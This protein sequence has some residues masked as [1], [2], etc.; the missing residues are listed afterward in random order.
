MLHSQF[1][2][3]IVIGAGPAGLAMSQQLSQRGIDHV[4]LERGQVANSW[5]TERWDSLKLLSPNWQTRLPAMAYSGADPDGFMDMPELIRFLDDYA[6]QMTAPIHTDVTVSS[7]CA[8]DDAYIRNNIRNKG[9]A[10]VTNRGQWNCRSLVIATGAFNIPVIPNVSQFVSSSTQMLTSHQY[11]NPDQLEK[12]GVLVVGASATG[13]QLASEIQASGRQVTLAAGEH[14]R[15]PRTYRGMDIFWWMQHTGIASE[16]LAQIDDVSRVRNLPSPQLIGSSDRSI[17]D[18][19]RL[20]E[21]GVQLTGRLMNANDNGLQF[22]GSLHN[23]CKLADL[24]MARLLKRFDQ[25]AEQ[26][27]L[28]TSLPEPQNF[29]PTRVANFS[30]L[31]LKSKDIKT[32]IWATGYRPDYSWLQLPVFNRKGQLMHSGGVVNSPGV[33][34]LGLPF[35]RRRNS[36]FIHGV[37]DDAC[38]LALHLVEYLE[39][40][41]LQ[42]FFALV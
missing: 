28:A 41:S 17:F 40:A 25:W 16:S 10:V 22:S 42:C 36:S 24:K 29:D 18:L 8:L 27:D 5:R 20:T 34:V 11:K 39:S 35:L 6:Q 14:V 19:N 37:A 13:L 15:M 4:V 9:Y 33:Y 38:E 23:V 3:T 21:Q 12:D 30:L 32:I 2:D 31:Q 7:V 26:N 1:I